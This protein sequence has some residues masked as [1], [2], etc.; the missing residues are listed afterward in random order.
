VPEIDDVVHGVLPW[1]VDP[2]A[3]A[4]LWDV[5]TALVGAEAV[6]LGLA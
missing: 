1:S 5:S 2:E 4:R 6:R 3:V